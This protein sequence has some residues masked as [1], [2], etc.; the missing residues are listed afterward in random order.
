MRKLYFIDQ[1]LRG[2]IAPQQSCQINKAAIYL[3]S[4]EVTKIR[5]TIEALFTWLIEETDLQRAS[6]M[7]SAKGLVVHMFKRVAAT[8]KLFIFNT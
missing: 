4:T 7:R 2:K 8:W 6:K 5:L 1:L 3:Y